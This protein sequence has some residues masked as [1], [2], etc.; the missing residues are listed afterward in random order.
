MA[1]RGV[2]AAASTH[3]YARLRPCSLARRARGT[4]RGTT[5]R[6]TPAQLVPSVRLLVSSVQLAR[7]L[8]ASALL[9]SGWSA[10]SGHRTAGHHGPMTGNELHQQ[11]RE[12][13]ARCGEGART[14]PH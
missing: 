2:V 11:M 8:P 13:T 3:H 9:V 5:R 12:L 10:R 4:V 14:G 7:V 6:I 1:N